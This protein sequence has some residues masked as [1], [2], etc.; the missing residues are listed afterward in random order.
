MV[1]REWAMELLLNNILNLT[2][3]QI[4]NSKIEFNMNIGKGG[5]PFIDRW[6]KCSETERIR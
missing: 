3:Q 2:E 6:L 1:F 5:M 4:S